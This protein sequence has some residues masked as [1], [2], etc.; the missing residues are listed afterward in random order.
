MAR[1]SSTT[2]TTL[3]NTLPLTSSWRLTA[4]LE[5]L[6]SAW[7]MDPSIVSVPTTQCWPLAA[8]VVLISP[9]L[10]HIPAL[11]MVLPWCLVL[12][13]PTRIWSLCSSTPQVSMVRVVLSLKDVEEKEV[14]WSTQRASASW[15]VML[16]LP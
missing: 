9:A 4:V 12:G 10:Q 14:T 16:Q 6:P 13:S 15:S 8:M 11:V 2:A 5:S 7:K 1:V 3:L